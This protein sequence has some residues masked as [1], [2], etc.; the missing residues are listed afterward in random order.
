M[1]RSRNIF[2]RKKI[3]TIDEEDVN[4]IS[5]DIETYCALYGL[6]YK[7]DKK[8]NE[9]LLA[10]SYDAETLNRIKQSKMTTKNYNKMKIDYVK[11]YLIK[12]NDIIKR[13]LLKIMC[14]EKKKISNL[15]Y[16]VVQVELIEPS[17]DIEFY[18]YDYWLIDLDG[19]HKIYQEIMVIDKKEIGKK[20]LNEIKN[21]LSDNNSHF[22]TSSIE[23]N[24]YYPHTDTD[25]Y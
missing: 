14:Y 25:K 10:I 6:F 8:S 7:K 18:F 20:E 24:K 13:M 11:T 12:K 21:I 2:G 17:E 3:Y 15:K 23:L 16:K 5:Y 1:I 22:S 4:N 19:H 9:V